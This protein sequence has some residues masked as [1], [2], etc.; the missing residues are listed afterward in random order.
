MKCFNF[1]TGIL[2]FILAFAMT[3]TAYATDSEYAYQYDL[4]LDDGRIVYIQTNTDNLLTDYLVFVTVDAYNTP[5]IVIGNGAEQFTSS[6]NSVSVSGVYRGSPLSYSGSYIL[7][8]DAPTNFGSGFT[9]NSILYSNRNIV[10]TN[11]KTIYSVSGSADPVYTISFDTGF[12]DVE[13][14][15]QT[16]DTFLIPSITKDGYTFLGWFLDETHTVPYTAD[17][18]FLQD[19]TLYAKWEEIPVTDEPIY[20][21]TFVTGFEDTLSNPQK[22]DNFVLPTL[23]KDGYIFAGWFTDEDS[24]IPYDRTVPFSGDTILYAKWIIPGDMNTFHETVFDSLV[25]LLSSEPIVYLL[26]I[27]GLLLIVGVFRKFVFP[28]IS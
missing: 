4:P 15:Q 18:V 26:S 16:T 9:L 2:A 28:L 1:K 3:V 10:D 17:Y 27:I 14:A 21:I 22:S 13:A 12:D 8:M 20:T 23:E 19:T 6:G 24:T 5:K 25:V 11:G 7:K